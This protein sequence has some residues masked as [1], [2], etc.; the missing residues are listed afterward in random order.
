MNCEAC[1]KQM[2]LL[3]ELTSAEKRA[4]ED[5]ISSCP[6]CGLQFR[7]LQ[8][9]A[10]LV[11]RASAEPVLPP[12]R[13]QLTGKIM[14]RV[15]HPEPT[16][17]A[18]LIMWLLDRPMLRYSL[19]VVSLVMMLE[20]VGEQQLSDFSEQTLKTT[21]TSNTIILDTQQFLKKIQERKTS[22]ATERRFSLIQHVKDHQT[23]RF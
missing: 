4:V 10:A 8:D 1:E 11:Q 18:S 3:S 22:S 6:S 12:N 23:K 7:M 16:R 2:Y 15:Q 5:H 19:A 9:A 20:F 14:S 17:G 13:G 21:T